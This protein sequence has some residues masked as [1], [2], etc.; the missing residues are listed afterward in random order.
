[1]LLLTAR[2]P[3]PSSRIFEKSS[4]S[5][6]MPLG[7]RLLLKACC[8]FFFFHAPRSTLLFSTVW[9]SRVRACMHAC[10]HSLTRSLARAVFCLFTLSWLV[11]SFCS[12][13]YLLLLT[14]SAAFR[15]FARDPSRIQAVGSLAAC[16]WCLAQSSPC[17]S[18][19][20]SSLD[21]RQWQ[22]S[23]QLLTHFL[24]LR[25]KPLH[26]LLLHQLAF[27]QNCCQ[28]ASRGQC[29]IWKRACIPAQ[30]WRCTSFAEVALVLSN[31]DRRNHCYLSPRLRYS[32]S[33]LFVRSLLF[34]WFAVLCFFVYF[35]SFLQRPQAQRLGKPAGKDKVNERKESKGKQH[36]QGQENHSTFSTEWYLTERTE[37]RK[38]VSAI[39]LLS[40]FPLL[41]L[42][43]LLRNW[44]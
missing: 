19:L 27:R 6:W 28:S 2:L 4:F 43:S 23:S 14:G 42:S 30:A 35:F 40:L 22:S 37:K 36:S 34:H 24:P 31:G 18:S 41:L 33:F 16:R 5:A 32:C 12:S 10:T 21:P 13:S 7:K 25:D 8:L 38:D 29:P 26:G 9:S 3:S 44:L 15:F 39:L 11:C 17:F 20:A 1:M